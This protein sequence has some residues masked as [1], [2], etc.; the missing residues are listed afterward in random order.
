MLKKLTQF[1]LLKNINMIQSKIA[2][3]F[4]KNFLIRKERIKIPISNNFVFFY[5]FDKLRSNFSHQIK[6]TYTSNNPIM[7]IGGGFEYLMKGNTFIDK[8]LF[9]K[10]VIEDKSSA[11]LITMPRRWGKSFNL[12]MLRLFLS[13]EGHDHNQK[14]KSKQ[15]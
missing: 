6:R 13:L 3:C 15:I 2:P 14:E 8:S 4:K 10:E 5:E 9:I 1:K 11:L 7:T 12:E